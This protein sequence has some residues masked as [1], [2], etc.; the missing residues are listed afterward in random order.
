MQ[1]EA[2]SLCLNNIIR[3]GR[4]DEILENPI[5]GVLAPTLTSHLTAT[6]ADKDSRMNNDRNV[7]ENGL[8]EPNPTVFAGEGSWRQRLKKQTVTCPKCEATWL[9]L[10]PNQEAPHI[11]KA[12]RYQFT[13]VDY[14]IG[15]DRTI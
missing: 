10:S 4:M 6:A 3:L 15:R 12:C 5:T 9:I 2:A 8:P 11:C 1:S 7:F 14:S 13:V